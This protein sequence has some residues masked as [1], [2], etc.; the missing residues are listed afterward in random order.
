[1]KSQQEDLNKI[2]TSCQKCIFAIYNGDTQT[3]CEF[4]KLDE[5]ELREAYNDDGKFYVL[6]GICNI[7]R[8]K[9]WN[10]GVKDKNKIS[11]EIA[12]KLLVIIDGFSLNS[13]A[14]KKINIEYKYPK[15]IDYH[16]IGPFIKEKELLKLKNKLNCKLTLTQYYNYA[17]H[18]I[19]KEYKYSYFTIL[20][21]KE[22][23]NINFNRFND[24]YCIK[25][26]KPVHIEFDNVIYTSCLLYSYITLKYNQILFDK[27]ME[28]INKYVISNYQK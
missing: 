23:T 15:N 7:L 10:N 14:L 21:N 24:K 18:K 16:I 27:N 13:M 1:M 20:N 3:G 5:Y 11:Q 9:D 26:N 19:I 22:C 17:M 4:N 12:F 25:K 8:H 28:E 2:C 6:N